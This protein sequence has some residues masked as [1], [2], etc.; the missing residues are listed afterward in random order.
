MTPIA[1]LASSLVEEFCRHWTAAD[2]SDIC[3]IDAN[4]SVNGASRQ[5]C[6]GGSIRRHR[7]GRGDIRIGAKVDIEQRTLRTFS[8]MSCVQIRRRA[9]SLAYRQYG[10]VVASVAEVFAV[11]FFEREGRL[12]IN[13]CNHAVLLLEYRSEFAPKGI[14]VE[15]FSHANADTCVLIHVGGPIPRWVLSI[16]SAPRASSS[17]RSRRKW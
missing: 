14:Y 3:F 16:L 13:L 1:Y 7:G 10:N 11:D 17:R 5:S 8:R 2:A 6:S 15:E 4:N 9:T 12:S